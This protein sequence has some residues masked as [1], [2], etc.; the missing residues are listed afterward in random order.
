MEEAYA[1]RDDL[2]TLKAPKVMNLRSDPF[3][4]AD[5]SGYH[6]WQWRAHRF[7]MM[8]PAGAIIAEFMKNMLEFPPRQSSEA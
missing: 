6:Y 5:I 3:N 4:E 2:M 1:W 8:L 7:F